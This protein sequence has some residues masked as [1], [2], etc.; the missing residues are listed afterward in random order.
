MLALEFTIRLALN[1][2]TLLFVYFHLFQVFLCMLLEGRREASVEEIGNF[3]D[4]IFARGR[5]HRANRFLQ[6]LIAKI[7][8]VLAQVDSDFASLHI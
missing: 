4:R 2:C 5:K 1:F 3:C 8:F 7:L 6:V